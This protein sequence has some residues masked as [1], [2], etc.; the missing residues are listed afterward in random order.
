MKIQTGKIIFEA[1][2]MKMKEFDKIKKK[3]RTKYPLTSK[4]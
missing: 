2:R 4:Y 1:Q 3:K